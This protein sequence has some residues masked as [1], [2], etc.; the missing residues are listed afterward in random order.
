MALAPASEPTKN[1][2]SDSVPMNTIPKYLFLCLILLMTGAGTSAQTTK[3]YQPECDHDHIE[4][5][6]GGVAMSLGVE[7]VVAPTMACLLKLW[8]ED[9][10]GTTKYYASTAFLA[11]MDQNPPLFF[12]AM[13]KEPVIFGE[14]LQ[15]LEASSFTWPLD[16]P[17]PLD[18]RRRQLISILQHTEVAAGKPSSLK[19]AVVK[20]L[21]AIRCRQIQ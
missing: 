20:K 19:D 21:S 8:R 11:I 10:G 12:I 15:E 1:G 3:A 17:C 2:R 4:S 6:V 9:R 18:M 16:P 13:A 14:W 7:R 5:L